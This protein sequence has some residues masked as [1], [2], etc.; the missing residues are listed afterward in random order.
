MVVI[1][2]LLLARIEH[3]YES[4]YQQTIGITFF[5]TPHRGSEIADYGG[6]LSK[7]ATNI[8]HKPDSKL[9]R[10]L[11]SN[12][13]ELVQLTSDF[14]HQVPQYSIVSFYE[15]KPMG[16][17]RSLVSCLDI[18]TAAALYYRLTTI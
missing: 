1:K 8:M 12:S 9:I 7:I 17:P 11:K 16:I 14:R 18:T 10:A 6:V 15:L 4:I 2:A 5:G 13:D 3:R